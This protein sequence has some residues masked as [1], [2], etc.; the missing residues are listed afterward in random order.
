MNQYNDDIPPYEI[1][2]EEEGTEIGV[3]KATANLR[4]TIMNIWK[5]VKPDEE[6]PGFDDKKDE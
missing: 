3:W 4:I 2:P 1:S 5:R 6:F